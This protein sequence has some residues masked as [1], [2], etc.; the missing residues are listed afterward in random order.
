MNGWKTSL[1]RFSASSVWGGTERGEQ[2]A[3]DHDGV[4]C[5]G[6][7]LVRLGA[8]WRADHA[9]PVVPD[10]ESLTAEYAEY[11][12]RAELDSGSAVPRDW[13]RTRLV[14]EPFPAV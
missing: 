10:Q 13:K 12:E 1:S 7:V 14:L 8:T 9:L 4:S 2:R 6:G 11:A 3:D 5:L